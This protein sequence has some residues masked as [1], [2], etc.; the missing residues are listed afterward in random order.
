MQS[1]KTEML[2]AFWHSNEY[3]DTFFEILP[4]FSS[5]GTVISLLYILPFQEQDGIPNPVKL[6]LGP[7][8]QPT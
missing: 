6:L 1:Y 5:F 4:R 2:L 7:N 8:K 3:E